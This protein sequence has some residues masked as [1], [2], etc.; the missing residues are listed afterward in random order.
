MY[1]EQ[2][3]KWNC[4]EVLCK[5][6]RRR[7]A[8][9]QV[10]Q[11]P[12]SRQTV[13]IHYGTWPRPAEGRSLRRGEVEYIGR[14]WNI[15]RSSPSVIITFT[16]PRRR[17]SISFIFMRM[18][19]TIL[20]VFALHQSFAYFLYNQICMPPK[21]ICVH[22]ITFLLS[23][24]WHISTTSSQRTVSTVSMGVKVNGFHFYE[25]INK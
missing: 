19:Y 9:I 24:N 11:R 5:S 22:S 18:L 21:Y 2:V 15:H 4:N 14:N 10:K 6:A 1:R 25:K 7:K 17:R 13:S 16:G 12:R 8:V 23:A 20:H 3:S